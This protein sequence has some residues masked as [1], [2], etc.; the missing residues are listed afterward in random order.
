MPARKS[1]T[2]IVPADQVER[3]IYLIRGHRVILS[4]DLADLYG[5]EVR[6]LNQ[7]VSRNRERF[8]DDFMFQLTGSEYRQLMSPHVSPNKATESP[9]LRS[10][11]V[12]LKPD[13]RGRHSKYRPYAFTEQ[14][15]AML[16]AVLRSPT[17][18]RVSIEI[19]RAFVRLRQILAT[20]QE[21]REKFEALE[22]KL[23]DHDE[24][25]AVVFDAIR[26]LMQPPEA[27]PEQ[28]FGFHPRRL[29]QARK[30]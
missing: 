27:L 20:H 25:F 13:L 2:A 12:I 30:R 10:Q 21:L 9:F 3:R 8:P 22:R 7:A 26:D 16:S 6:T 19:V 17:A 1:S 28:S 29:P 15:V 23:S 5:V 4:S 24:R 14:G 11:S 18:I